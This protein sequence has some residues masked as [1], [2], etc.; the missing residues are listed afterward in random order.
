MKKSL[1]NPI[2]FN[3]D[4]PKLISLNE[5]ESESLFQKVD[6]DKLY[7]LP[8]KIIRCKK[9]VITN[10]RPRITI[11]EDGICNACKYWEKKDNEINWEK[12]SYIFRDL[13]DKFRSSDGSFD[14]LVPSSGG[15]DSSLVA[16][17]LKDEYGMHPLTVTWAPSLYTEVGYLNFQNHIHNGLDNVKV[18]ANGLVHRR[19]C[20][21]S[22]IVMGDPFQ[23]F[24]YGQANTPLRIAKAYDIG[25]IVDG[26]N[27]EVEYGG[28]EGTEDKIG[29]QE[30]D[31]EKFWLSGI[32]VEYWQDFGY[33]DSELN[34]YQAPKSNFK[35]KRVF[36]SY[37][38]NWRPH[39]HFYY[40][41]KRAGFISNP[42]R[43]ECTYSRYASLDDAIDPFH[44]YLGLLKFGIGRATSDAAHEIREGIIDRDEGMALV[45]KF[46]VQS[47]SEETTR[48]FMHYTSLTKDELRQVINK[49][50]NHNVWEKRKDFPKLKL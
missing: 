44:Y 35:I 10:Q 17:K 42:D 34:V 24:I 6:F 48:L 2:D 5:K 19:L 33:S 13:C 22:S 30:N 47:P 23:P 38:H 27:G 39:D 4:W 20:R 7:K 28:D 32:P 45:K 16:F 11:N 18:T 9:C 41:S 21:S 1:F 43:S 49:W 25:L 8:K 14:V 12:R 36:F 46:D 15:K 31:S 3:Q 40:V 37:Y 26:E 50:T 29:F